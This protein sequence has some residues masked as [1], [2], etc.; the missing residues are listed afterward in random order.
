MLMAVSLDDLRLLLDVAEL[1]S[2]SQAAARRGWSQ[3]QVSQRIAVLEQALGHA[4]FSRHRRGA[5]A[6]EA[7]KAFLG[8][9]RQAL[10]AYQQGQEAML[11]SPPLPRLHLASLSSL[12]SPV[13]GPLL[14]KLVDAPIEIRCDI[15]H[16]QQIMQDLLTGEADI[17]FVLKCPAVA[18]IQ[19]ELLWHSPIVPVV[20]AQHPLAAARQPLTLQSVADYRIAPQFWDDECEELIRLIRRVRRQSGAIHAV[21]PAS[22]ARELVLRHAFLSFMPELSI[23]NDLRDGTMI[24]L[25]IPELPAWQWDVMMAYRTGKRKAEAKRIVLEAARQLTVSAI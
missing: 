6:T 13:F 7:C 14:V 24:R 17:G 10:A 18:G 1:G 3:P 20:A 21:Q 5:V 25:D 19:M 2:F 9:A 8:P 23:R 15:G 4:L 22:A 12:S 16:S 11:S